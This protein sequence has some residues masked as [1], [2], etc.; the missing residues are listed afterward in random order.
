MAD[1]ATGSGQGQLQD[2]PPLSSHPRSPASLGEFSIS[3]QGTFFCSPLSKEQMVTAA[4]NAESAKEKPL[5][6]HGPLRGPTPSVCPHH[7]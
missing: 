4:Q 7:A 2:M 3:K 1:G 5:H 6:L